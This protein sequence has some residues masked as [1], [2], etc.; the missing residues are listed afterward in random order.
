[1]ARTSAHWQPGPRRRLCRSTHRRGGGGRACPI[2]RDVFMGCG[3]CPDLTMVGRFTQEA[4]ESQNE[5]TPPMICTLHEGNGGIFP[6]SRRGFS[7]LAVDR[8]LWRDL[9]MTPFHQNWPRAEWHEVSRKPFSYRE[10]EGFVPCA[11][12]C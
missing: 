8:K 2:P 4:R 3:Q 12:F 5:N 1:M 11:T 7:H 6:Q 9:Q 10:L